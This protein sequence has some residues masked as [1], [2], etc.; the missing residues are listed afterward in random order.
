MSNK[1]IMFEH[2]IMTI[3]FEHQIMTTYMTP[4]GS[5]QKRGMATDSYEGAAP[6]NTLHHK[7][8]TLNP[9][10]LTIESGLNPEP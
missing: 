5:A 2:Q 1:K 6:P 7:P 9:D 4:V 3:I 10:P 8:S